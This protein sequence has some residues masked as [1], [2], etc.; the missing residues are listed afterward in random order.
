[1]KEF[2]DTL[3][4]IEKPLNDCEV[5][6]YIL[7]WLNS[8]YDSF[9]TTITTWLDPISME[10]LYGH[11]LTFES[12][13]EQQTTVPDIV[14]PSTNVITKTNKNR[15]SGSSHYNSIHGNSSTRSKGRGR[16]RGRGPPHS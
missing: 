13:L 3:A 2:E 5:V 1:M 7:S 8:E 9:V 4:A 16:D 11:L 12:Q 6:S 15:G 10:E 14:F